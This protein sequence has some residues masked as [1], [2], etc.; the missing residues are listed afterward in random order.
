MAVEQ[1]RNKY[2]LQVYVQKAI[3]V[4]QSNLMHTSLISASLR[5]VQLTCYK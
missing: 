2:Y 3:F 5:I 1:S 4:I